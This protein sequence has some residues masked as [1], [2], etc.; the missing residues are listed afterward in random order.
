M[1]LG[2]D[3]YGPSQDVSVILFCSPLGHWS[4]AILLCL[5]W[6]FSLGSRLAGPSNRPG[7]MSNETS[8]FEGAEALDLGHF[9]VGSNRYRSLLEGLYTL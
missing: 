5:L 3:G 7:A 9:Q 2:Q 6:G 1:L 4:V 8:A